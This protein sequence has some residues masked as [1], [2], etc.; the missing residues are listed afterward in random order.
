MVSEISRFLCK[1]VRVRICEERGRNSTMFTGNFV[2]KVRCNMVKLMLGLSLSLGYFNVCQ[3]R[4]Q[5]FC[6]G[7]GVQQIQLRTERTGIWER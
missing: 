1:F 7:G 4:T 2:M 3:W 6:S 5:E